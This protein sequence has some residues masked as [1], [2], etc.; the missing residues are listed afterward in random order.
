VCKRG[1]HAAESDER[2]LREPV[3]PIF[4][5]HFP[6]RD[7]ELT[8][9]RLDLLCRADDSGATRAR[10][11][12]DAS[13]GILLR[14]KTLDAVYAH[15]WDA[16]AQYRLTGDFSVERPIPWEDAVP[17]ADAATPRWYPTER[18]ARSG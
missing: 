6:Y 3:T 9:R 16:V 18:N 7:E 1:F 2:P 17:A 8:R 11:G 10:D 4:L 12:D 14:Y 13:E 15:D 5:H